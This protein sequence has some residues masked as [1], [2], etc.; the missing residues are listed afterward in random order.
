MT[1]KP[2]EATGRH[3]QLKRG[4]PLYKVEAPK[5]LALAPDPQ[6]AVAGADPYNLLKEKPEI[7]DQARPRSLDDMR[8]LSHSIKSTPQWTRPQKT[9]TSALYRR[10]AELRGDLERV[11]AEIEAIREGAAGTGNRHVVELVGELRSA[12]YQL[13]GA[14]ASLSKASGLTDPKD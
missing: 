11:L 14:I 7:T 13:E 2:G 1:K 10:L 3:A 12:A 9:T 6:R 8:R 5:D 4:K